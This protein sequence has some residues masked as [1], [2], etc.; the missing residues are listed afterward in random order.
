VYGEGIQN[1]MNDAPADISIV[2]NDDPDKPIVGEALP[3][4]GIVAFLDHNWSERWSSTIGYSRTDIDNTD[5]ATPTAY[6]AGQYGL[7]NLLYMPVPNVMMGGEL[8]W[9][10]R[11]NE[12]GFTSDAVKVQ[13]S[14]KY[15]FSSRIGG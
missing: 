5:L 15:N 2:T 3:I 10:E 6:K 9:G 8:Q 12:N 13:F 1:Y 4:T 11:E 14:F 7:F